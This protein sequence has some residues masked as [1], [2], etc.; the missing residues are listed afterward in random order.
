MVAVF[1]EPLSDKSIGLLTDLN[2]QL[3]QGRPKN[4][5]DPGLDAAHASLQ[6]LITNN[7]TSDITRK[8]QPG[9]VWRS[10][11][12]MLG[13]PKRGMSEDIWTAAFVI[14]ADRYSYADI[15]ACADEIAAACQRDGI[16]L[17]PAVARGA[18]ARG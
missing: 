9:T 14:S 10:L 6:S 7:A 1:S 2:F 8:S 5:V 16:S 3:N 15:Q 13:N 17:E 18:R 12:T 11:E 4:V